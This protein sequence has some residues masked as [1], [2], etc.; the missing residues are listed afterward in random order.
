ME[1]LEAGALVQGG[2]QALRAGLV[3][4][5]RRALSLPAVK[6]QARLLLDRLCLLGDGAMEAGRRRQRAEQL[7][8]VS[9]RE[10]NA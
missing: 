3:A 7:E 4:T 6:Q 9:S 2:K 5:V 8:A 1:R 10:R